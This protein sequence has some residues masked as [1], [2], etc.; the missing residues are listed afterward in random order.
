VEE[1]IEETGVYSYITRIPRRRRDIRE[2]EKVMNDLSDRSGEDWLRRHVRAARKAIEWANKQV[3]RDT[4]RRIQ[5][6][7]DKI[8]QEQGDQAATATEDELIRSAVKSRIK[9]GV[10]LRTIYEAAD[11]IIAFEPEVRKALQ[12]NDARSTAVYAVPLGAA[13]ERLKIGFVEHFALTGRRV[14]GGGHFGQGNPDERVQ[15]DQ[16]IADRWAAVY[17]AHPDW[18]K[19]QINQVV[20]EETG[21]SESTVKRARKNQKET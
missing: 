21:F 12:S 7:V 17:A 13:A 3:D 5:S 20:M 8:R 2:F 4:Y 9:E 10:T 14:H 1:K 18:S 16:N 15:R 19:G 6:E 11:E